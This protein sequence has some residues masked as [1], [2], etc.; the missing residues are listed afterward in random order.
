MRIILPIKQVPETAAV[1]MDEKTG[2][3]IRDGVEA[4]INPL[5]LYAIEAA[6]RLRDTHGGEI[7]AVTMGPPKAMSALREAI[8]MGVDRA[9]LLSDKAF[10]GAD[11]WATS[12]VLAEAIKK[13]GAC[14]LII[15]GERATDGDTGQV[16]PGIAAWLNLPL[17]TYVGHIDVKTGDSGSICTV[18][19][20]V[21]D[22]VERLAMQ[23]PGVLT[24]IKEVG[25][26]RLPTLRG[27][28]KA[29]A[30]DVPV[31]GQK[32]LNLDPKN[33]GLE[34][35]PTRVVKIFRPK[36][37][38]TCE[39]IVVTDSAA[40]GPAVDKL[41][42]FISSRRGSSADT[43]RTDTAEARRAAVSST[44]PT[45][46]GKAVCGG[47]WVLGEQAMGRVQRITHELLTRGRALAD[48]RGVPLTAVILGHTFDEN[49]LREVGER[50]ADRVLTLEHP[51]FAEFTCEPFTAGLA[52]LVEQ[53][54]PEIIIAGATTTGRTVM[55]CL[56]IKANTGLTADCTGLEIEPE[57][58]NLL[59]TRP[60]I[61]G[62]IMATIKTPK[63]RPQM[64]TVRP[65]S[66]PP[67][68]RQ[69]GRTCQIERRAFPMQNLDRRVT[70]L[71]FEARSEE[72]GL[73]EAETVVCVGRGI[74]RGENLPLARRLAN[75][76]NGALGATRDVVDRGWLDYPH[77]IGLS[78]KTVTPKLYVSIGVSGAI[79]HLAGMQTAETIIAIDQ[80]PE[81][82]IFKV[83][84]FGLVGDLFVIVP[85]LIEKLEA[86]NRTAKGA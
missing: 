78:G 39:K 27:K 76:L 1:K 61:G 35:S 42:S 77:Q 33:L 82:Q 22:G 7:I 54:K 14:D 16:G 36:V 24:V 57:T 80:D 37:T 28:Q 55:P 67:A 84:D 6:I 8:A 86:A 23:M 52:W 71:G 50:G 60:A 38:R 45:A 29:R 58:G 63:H 20:E 81:A 34:G 59:Q 72:Q 46:C 26:P 43:T 73:S 74:K 17:I 19:R 10:A 69:A 79:Q 40:A 25:D 41:I 12:Y 21:E 3:M 66:T 2:T 51:D 15:C 49:D 5:D 75:G 18:K 53:E 56:A 11:T 9:V 4:I 70:R 64:S 32:E 85:A 65:R 48:A 13:L 62:N 83:A 47:I 31:W 68:P 30:A 44:V